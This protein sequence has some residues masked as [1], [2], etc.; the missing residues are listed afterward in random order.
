MGPMGQIKLIRLIG[1]I[2]PMR[3]MRTFSK[4]YGS[5]GSQGEW[6]TASQVPAT[7]IRLILIGRAV[8][9]QS[10]GEGDA[11]MYATQFGLRQR[12]FPTT[13][14][15]TAYYPATTH[16]RA[17]AR[18]LQG[19]SDDE[20]I[21]LLTGEP[22]TGKTLLCH[23]LAERLGDER[24][25][26]FLTNCHFANRAALF[27]ALLFDLSLPYDGRGEQEMRLALTDHLLNRYADGQATVLLIDEAQHLSTDLLEELRLLGNLEARAGKAVQI[28]L[29]GWPSLIERLGDPALAALRQRLVVKVQLE[30]L[31]LHEAADYLLHHLRAAGARAE[32]VL[33]A[34]ALELLARS[35][36]GIPRLLNQA[37]HQAFRLA[38]EADAGQVDVEAVLEALS[39]LGLEAI[40]AP[41]ADRAVEESASEETPANDAEL[42]PLGVEQAA[43]ASPGDVD[44]SC[45]LFVSPRLA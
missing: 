35:T 25:L 13:P 33:A 3:P 2:G 17:L 45:R 8:S 44:A 20:G 14:D 26:I 23:C 30:P 16:E 12:P 27:Q 32:N 22:G 34:E 37:A 9:A 19:L 11:G 1:P 6:I 43:E 39:V 4:L 7:F 41:A 24:Q 31:P 15:T 29:A 10:L 18:L 21:L 42:L 5:Y 36:Q 38:T 40:E 28:V